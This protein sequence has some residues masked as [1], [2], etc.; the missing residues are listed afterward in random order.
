MRRKALVVDDN[1]NN[2]ML[3]KDLLE[4]AGFEVFEAENAADG[5]AIAKKEKP[6]IILMD[7][8]LSDMR[9]TKAA[10]ILREDKE[11]RDIPI[12]FV[13]SSVMAEGIEET[14]DIPNSGFIGKPINTRTFVQEIRRFI[15]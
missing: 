1:K 8:R 13:T 6:D 3:E 2:L 11:T 7:V 10:R 9:G 4:V 12:V 14:K 5:M 15:K